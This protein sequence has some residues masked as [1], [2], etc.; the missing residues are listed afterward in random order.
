MTMIWHGLSRRDETKIYYQHS[1]PKMILLRRSPIR[2]NH[3]VVLWRDIGI[4]ALKSVISAN[5]VFV[6]INLNYKSYN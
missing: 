6:L 2:R 5:R 3:F 1:L 4:E